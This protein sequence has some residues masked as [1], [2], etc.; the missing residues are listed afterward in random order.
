MA[1]IHFALNLN[2]HQPSG[3]LERLLNQDP[4]EAKQ[5]LQALNR[6]PKALWPHEKQA[7]LHVSLSGTLLETLSNPD[8]QA[9]TYEI[10]RC[11]DFLYHLQNNKIF[12]L[13]ATAYYHPIF[14]LTPQR[15]WEPQVSRWQGLGWHLFYKSHFSGFWPPELAVTMDMI[16][17]LKRMGFRYLVA[18]SENIEPVDDMSEE[19][20]LFQPHIARHEGEEIRVVVRHRALSQALE[21]GLSA[22]D[23]ILDIEQKTRGLDFPLLLTT[24][25]NGDNGGLFRNSSG[26]G[27]FWTKFYQPLMRAVEKNKT[28]VAPT[29][30]TEYLDRFGAHGEVKLKKGTWSITDAQ[31]GPYSQWTGTKQQKEAHACIAHISKCVARAQKCASD[32]SWDPRNNQFVKEAHWR[33]LRAQTSCNFFWGEEWLQYCHQDLQ[34]AEKWLERVHIEQNAQIAQ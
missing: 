29:F 9:R 8:F 7:R 25:F 19:E 32:D 12:E 22:E 24:C 26:K 23:F 21:L 15:D 3:N 13:L 5:I 20:F 18:D 30:V 34:M 28:R 33:L 14:P 6:M 31:H 17:M 2:L 27:N 11:G 1:P 16:P 4:W 10:M